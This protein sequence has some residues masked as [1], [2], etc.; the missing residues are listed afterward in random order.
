MNS[1]LLTDAGVTNWLGSNELAWELR[2]GH[3]SYDVALELPPTGVAR[4]PV[5]EATT[6]PGELAPTPGCRLGGDAASNRC[7]VTGSWWWEEGL[8]GSSPGGDSSLLPEAIR[9]EGH[10]HYFRSVPEET[11][12]EGHCHYFSSVPEEPSRLKSR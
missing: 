4:W 2:T 12:V 7:S 8:G 11:R 10:C 3:M 1:D 6:S 5:G 9:V